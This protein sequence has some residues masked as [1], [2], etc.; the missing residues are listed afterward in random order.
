MLIVTPTILLAATNGLRLR[1]GWEV[2]AQ[3]ALIVLA[4]AAIFGLPHA[5]EYQLFYLLFVPLLW[6]A[7]SNGV[8]GA[9]LALCVIQVGL[10]TIVNAPF[11]APVSLM[12]FQIL[13]IWLAATGLIFGSLVGQQRAAALRLR[14]Q[15]M[16][17]ERALRLQSMGELASSIAHEVNQPLTSI[18]AL[19]G[20][21]GR[22]MTSEVSSTSKD[23]IEKIRSECDRASQIIRA[24]RSAL[25]QQV[26]RPGSIVTKQLLAE[27][28]ELVADRLAALDVRLATQISPTPSASMATECSS[29]RHF[30]TC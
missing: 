30:T 21:L 9:A 29:A 22:E 12:S 24:T 18:K 20:V 2:F 6:S 8:A 7:F 3:V 14:Y 4:L 1:I 15:Q 5:R 26:F 16:A 23:T 11:M 13:M 10:I 17:L 25:H 28:A 19:A 27:T